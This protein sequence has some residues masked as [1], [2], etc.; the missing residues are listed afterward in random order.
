MPELPEVETTLRGI[1]PHVQQQT[2]TKVVVRNR[3]LR[4]PV[5]RNIETI[6]TGQVI[7]QL[8]RRGKYLIFQCDAGSILLHLGMSGRLRILQNDTAPQKH[9]HVEIHFAHGK[10]LRFTDPRRF[11]AVLF[12]KDDP[13]THPLLSHLGPEPL[14]KSF[15]GDYLAERAKSRQLAVKSFIMDGKIVVGVGNIYAAEALYLAGIHPEQPAGTIRLD[16][17]HHLVDAIKTILKQAVKKGGTTLKDFSQSDGSPGYFSIELK[18][19]G[20]AGQ[21]CPSCKSTFELLRIGQR[22]TVFCP[23]CQPLIITNA[24]GSA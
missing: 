1:L 20:K 16:K 13:L 8:S 23:T 17:F 4:W 18:V 14:T 5:T 24:A 12:T 7:N 19:Y 15:H 11:G 6:L 10:M 9:D 3:R 2:I 21:P 22:S